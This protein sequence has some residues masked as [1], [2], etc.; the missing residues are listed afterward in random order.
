[1]FGATKGGIFNTMAD[2]NAYLVPGVLIAFLAG[3]FQ[4]Y[5][6]P[7]G[8]VACIVAGPISSVVFEQS[9]ARLLSHDLQAFH[10]AG[11]ASVGSY[12]VLLLVSAATQSERSPEREQ[13]LW[14]TYRQ[15]PSDESPLPRPLWQSDKAW[16]AV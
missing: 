1:Q 11:L 5:V 12:V 15:N 2:Y 10:R 9:A 7:T 14:W 13:Y 3:I 6:T 16:A 4:K 8:A